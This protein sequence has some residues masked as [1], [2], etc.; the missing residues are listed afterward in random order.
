MH[1]VADTLRRQLTAFASFT[2]QALGETDVASL[3]R[4][5]CL[6]ARAGLNMSHAKLLEYI[7][8]RD[9][10]LLVAGI[11]WKE[12]YVGSYSAP[13][14]LESPIGHAFGLADPVVIADYRAE[15]KFCYPQLLRDHGCVSSIN[16]PVRTDG[17]LFGVLEVDDLAPRDF[18]RDDINFLSGL[19]NTIGQAIELRRA[20]QAMDAALEE[21]A[22]LAREL[23]HRVKNNLSL[24]A[25]ML[26]LQARRF[27]DSSVREEWD[28]AIQRIQNLALV[29][30]RLQLSKSP[31]VDDVE[32]ADHFRELKTLL[33]SLLPSG[34][35]LDTDCSG[36][37][38]TASLESL[39]L[40]ANELV[41]NAAK[42]AFEGR[43]NG[44]ITVGYRREGASGW[45]LWVED[46]GVGL[47]EDF[48]PKAGK[49]FGHQLID[50]LVARL[51]AQLQV[52]SVGGTRT[53]VFR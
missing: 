13:M 30:D 23:N 16:V 45:R 29:H 52:V 48:D 14:N 47:P 11:G 20:L 10:L 32:A 19:G 24:A 21:R 15:A 34:V 43:D 31:S 37:I 27:E 4:D 33:S 8:D 7:P 35:V 42:H 41:T 1:D 3:M 22:L 9:V 18:T 49:S 28:A 12:G 36:L 25:A 53:E 38:D 39:T 44:R 46:D 50:I 17:K 26:H 2:S 5:A 40:I 51:N 6:K